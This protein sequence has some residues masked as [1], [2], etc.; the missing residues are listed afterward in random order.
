MKA[1]A[2]GITAHDIAPYFTRSTLDIIYQTSSGI[3][4]NAQTGND[5]STWNIITN[6]VDTTAMKFL[7]PW[8]FIDWIFNATELGKKYNKA[9]Q[10]EHDKIINEMAKKRR[11]RE[12]THTR[13]L[14]DEKT[15]LMDILIQ[16]EDNNNVEIVGEIFTIVGGGTE[17]T[18][19]ACGYVLACLG[20]TNTSRKE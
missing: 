20:T 18:S 5:D 19:N 7:K 8:L 9:I 13:G 6:I 3:N 1:L 15:S 4:T 11:T 10:C 16:Y 12:T 17:T 14:N 2:D